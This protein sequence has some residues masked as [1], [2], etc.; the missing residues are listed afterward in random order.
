MFSVLWQITFLCNCGVFFFWRGWGTLF[1]SPG[2]W[3]FYNRTVFQKLC[4][5]A[6]RLPSPGPVLPRFSAPIPRAWGAHA[7]TAARQGRPGGF[8]RFGGLSLQSLR[9]R[10]SHCFPGPG[11][12]SFCSPFHCGDAFARVLDGVSVPAPLLSCR[13]VGV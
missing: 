10:A 13:L 7:H 4:Q 3:K 12:E 8:P 11:A 9:Q 6:Q 2:S 5:A 1:L